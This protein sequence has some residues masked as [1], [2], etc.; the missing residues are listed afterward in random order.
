NTSR[1]LTTISVSATMKAV[2]A[3]CVLFVGAYCAPMLDEQLNSQW[4]LFKRV[5]AKQ[6]NTIEE[7]TAR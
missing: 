5:H 7:E 2:I 3:L 6:Y 4:A 1:R